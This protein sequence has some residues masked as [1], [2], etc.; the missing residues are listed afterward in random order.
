MDEQGSVPVFVT[1]SSKLLCVFHHYHTMC[2]SN[3]TPCMCKCTIA[4]SLFVFTPSPQ[5]VGV[6]PSS[7]PVLCY[8]ITT[9]CAALEQLSLDIASEI[10]SPD[11]CCQTWQD[12]TRMRDRLWPQYILIMC[13]LCREPT[14]SI[15]NCDCDSQESGILRPTQIWNLATRISVEFGLSD[16]RILPGKFLLPVSD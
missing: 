14:K 2:Y 5:P 8:S 15:E 16:L 4:H 12:K 6:S 9:A 3:I 11:R 13:S 10:G 1:P 7:Q